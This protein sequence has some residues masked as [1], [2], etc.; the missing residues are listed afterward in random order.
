MRGKAQPRVSFADLES[1]LANSQEDAEL[2]QFVSVTTTCKVLPG[3]LAQRTGVTRNSIYR[4]RE[5]GIPLFAADRI[6]CHMG[7]HPL[8]IWPDFHQEESCPR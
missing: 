2:R 1:F 6:A 7:V 8:V 4:W 5:T 3:V